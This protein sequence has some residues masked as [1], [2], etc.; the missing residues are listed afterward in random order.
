MKKKALNPLESPSVRSYM[1]I[2]KRILLNNLLIFLICG[3]IFSFKI[4]LGIS[5]TTLFLLVDPGHDH[6]SIKNELRQKGVQIRQSAPPNIIVAEFPAEISPASFPFIRHIYQGAIPIRELKNLG[7]LG[8]A[9]AIEWNRTLPENEKLDPAGGLRAMS[10]SV[11][12]RTLPAPE[13]LGAT[14]HGIKVI[15]GWENAPGAQLTEIQ[16]AR[17]SSFKNIFNTSRTDQNTIELPI[18]DNGHPLI[19]YIRARHI[20]RPDASNSAAD[21]MGPWSATTVTKIEFVDR[22]EN[23]SAPVLTSPVN[24]YQTNG[25]TV[26]LE[27]NTKNS[28]SARIQLSKFDDFSSPWLDAVVK[29]KELAVPSTALHVGDTIY[30]R[31]MT[32]DTVTSPWSVARRFTVTAPTHPETDMFINPEAPK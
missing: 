12:Q 25:F 5:S 20:D 30:W 15:C 1:L 13:S 11:S 31:V 2:V 22:L 27:W 6:V 21:V 10:A 17:D 32:F 26:F 7:P 16:M 28:D 8:M 3:P 19:A 29:T 18:P 9:A 24:D 23:Q 4:A 14:T